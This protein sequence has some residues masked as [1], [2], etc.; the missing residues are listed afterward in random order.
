VDERRSRYKGDDGVVVGSAM[1]ELCP[2]PKYGGIG[3]DDVM[4]G[5][6]LVEPSLDFA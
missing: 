5:Q 2:R 6:L 4:H 3:G 1:H